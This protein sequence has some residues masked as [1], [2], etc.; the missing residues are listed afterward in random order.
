MNSVTLRWAARGAGVLCASAAM[1]LG[2]AGATAAAPAV[3]PAAP[4]VDKPAS[5]TVH[6]KDLVERCHDHEAVP[7]DADL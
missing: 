2:L 6:W 7:D 3:A 1:I 5:T 4:A